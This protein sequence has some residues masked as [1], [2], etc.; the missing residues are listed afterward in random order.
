MS[1]PLTHAHHP[2]NQQQQPAYPHPQPQP[3]PYP[4]SE[5]AGP[6]GGFAGYPGTAMDMRGAPP[7]G[8]TGGGGQGQPL[9]HYPAGSPPP[10]ATATAAMPG[11]PPAVVM[12]PPTAAIQM[13]GHGQP[14][15]PPTS[16]TI[17]AHL[18]NQVQQMQHMQLLHQA[19]AASAAAAGMPLP[20]NANMLQAASVLQQQQ[21][22]EQMGIPQ[23]PATGG[24]TSAAVLPPPAEY[25]SLREGRR[26]VVKQQATKR[27]SSDRGV[28]PGETMP[29]G[30]GS[31]CNGEGD[32][33]L[34]SVVL[35]GLMAQI[36]K[37]PVDKP[38]IRWPSEGDHPDA[39]PVRNI[40]GE[41]PEGV[42]GTY[43][44]TIQGFPITTTGMPP[45][46]QLPQGGVAP[47]PHGHH[48][49]PNA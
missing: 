22:M 21:M 33:G 11:G 26:P 20:P 2:S 34:L 38:D 43:L 5:M 18:L 29:N 16:A 48:G 39:F 17:P 15:G 13:G 44:G 1:Y 37:E 7:G 42:L 27:D 31:M 6:G 35:D 49:G 25:T 30:N 10:N 3:H 12:Y 32:S 46:H 36:A 40:F 47:P 9:N 45:P 24:A 19:I 14:G 41:I 8:V 4:T 23:P 28:G